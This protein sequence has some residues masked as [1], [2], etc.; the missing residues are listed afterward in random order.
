[1]LRFLGRGEAVFGV[2]ARAMTRIAGLAFLAGALLIASDVI[3]RNFLGFSTKSSIELSGYILAFG[4]SWSLSGALEA[5]AHVRIDVLVQRVPPRPR[6]VLHALALG[7]LAVFTGFL[8][9]QAWALVAE[10]HLFRAT[11]IS[12]LAVPLV[13]PQGLWAFGIAV[14]FAMVMFRLVHVLVLLPSGDAVAI[15]TLTG[16]RSY[17]EEARETLEALPQNP[18]ATKG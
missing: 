14:F 16:P 10:S 11:D 5:R 1:M 3:S 15:E 2:I 6:C 13:I 8:A 18:G 9:Y 17:Q 4:L 7:A 12:A